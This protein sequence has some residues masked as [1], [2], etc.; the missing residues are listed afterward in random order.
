MKLEDA[1][2]LARYK[3]GPLAYVEVRKT[4]VSRLYGLEGQVRGDDG[5]GETICTVG[6]IVD[7]GP[8]TGSEI[9]AC[10]HGNSWD[11]AFDALDMW[12][13]ASAASSAAAASAGRS[14][15][16]SLIPA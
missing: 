11:D 13:T 12:M 15:P 1:L 5:G 8:G 6:V 3:L 9:R 2:V 16:P 7:K 10:G 4:S 14:A